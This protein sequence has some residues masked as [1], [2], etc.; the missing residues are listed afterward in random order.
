MALY[1][2]PSFSSPLLYAG[3]CS[4]IVIMQIKVQQK[5]VRLSLG[6]AIYPH[7]HWTNRQAHGSRIWSS[8]HTN[9]TPHI[10]H[11]G[12]LGE[13]LGDQSSGKW[14]IPCPGCRRT[15]HECIN[16]WPTIHFLLLDPLCRT[17]YQLNYVAHLLTARFATTLKRFYFLG[18][19]PSYNA[20]C[21]L[22]FLLA[23]S[24]VRCPWTGA[25]ANYWLID[26]FIYLVT[27]RN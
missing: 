3:N 11:I 17:P 10:P 7:T 5:Q 4:G 1:K 16:V 24:I 6:M 26:W 18:F 12:L 13:L 2:Y 27:H 20:I 8:P 22:Y 25:I 15:S 23:Y 9:C 14:E 21:L 19:T